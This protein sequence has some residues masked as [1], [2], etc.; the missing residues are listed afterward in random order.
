MPKAGYEEYYNRADKMIDAIFC[1]RNFWMSVYSDEESEDDSISKM[2][3]RMK[4]AFG[5][6]CPY[7][8]EYE[9][10]ARYPSIGISLVEGLAASVGHI[11]IL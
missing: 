9:P 2:A 11:I 8:H 3:T 5:F 4:G 1:H 6:P 10:E 7:G